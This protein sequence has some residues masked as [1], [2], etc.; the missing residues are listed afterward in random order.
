[1]KQITLIF[2]IF[3]IFVFTSYIDINAQDLPQDKILHFVISGNLFLLS[4][5]CFDTFSNINYNQNY[6]LSSV[7]AFIPE[8]LKEIYDSTKPDN[9]F[10][11]YD[12]LADITGILFYEFLVYIFNEISENKN[13]VYIFKKRSCL[14]FKAAFLFIVG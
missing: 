9:F 1:M 5:Y 7:F 2:F 4:F 3:F 13:T 11:V 10:D 12:L 14:N 6:F 8:I